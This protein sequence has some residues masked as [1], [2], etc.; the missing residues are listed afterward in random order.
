MLL[1]A[2]RLYIFFPRVK[3]FISFEKKYLFHT[4]FVKQKIILNTNMNT[5]N[6]DFLALIENKIPNFDI[7]SKEIYLDFLPEYLNILLEKE[8]TEFFSD[9]QTEDALIDFELFD[10]ESRL[11]YV[12]WLL[13]HID[14]VYG[15]EKS[16]TIIDEFEPKYIEFSQEV[17]FSKRYYEMYKICL[18]KW[19]LN[20]E[21]EKILKDVI[22]S[23]EVR[24]IHLAEGKQEELKMIGKILAE[25]SRKF[26]EN[27]LLSEWEITFSIEDEDSIEELPNDVKKEA[28]EKAKKQ[29]MR[30][31][32]FWSSP[33]EY[34]SV[35]KY[36]SDKEKRKEI[37]V[38]RSQIASN[39]K[40]DN[41][42]HV[43]DIL[44]LRQ[45]KSEI[46]WF[47]NY[48]DLS[49]YFKMAE[50]ATEVLDLLNSIATR[51]KKKAESEL[52]ML[53]EYFS[54]DTIDSE[55][56]AYYFRK[57]KEL[58]FEID[59]NVIKEYFEY[60][61]VLGW[62]FSIMNKLY[63]VELKQIQEQE[64]N[65]K[66]YE[67][68]KEWKLLSYFLIDPF[69]RP[70]KRSWAWYVGVKEKWH[71]NIPLVVN[72]YNIKKWKNQ[73]LL[74]M[75][76]VETV[77]HE[78]WHAMHNM[79]SMSQY[80][81]LTWTYVEHDFV[82]VPSQF[83]E[84]FCKEKECLELFAKHYKTWKTIP[85]IY[86]KKLEQLEQVGVWNMILWQC[87]YATLDM[88]LHQKR[89]YDSIEDL[90]NYILNL[91]NSISLIPKENSYKMYTSFSHIF[92]GWYASGYY[93][94]LWSEIL[95][96]D[97]WSEFLKAW[98]F[99][100][101]I[102]QKFYNNILS[103]GSKKDAKD[104]FYDFLGREKSVEWFLKAKWI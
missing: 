19:W 46:L 85:E 88:S 52:G 35:M 16:R 42:Q 61:T 70:E 77:F 17:W 33:S 103:Q 81:E 37:F 74:R 21:Q 45:Q 30:G 58:E 92:D 48:S 39:W 62:M 75:S 80:A 68:Y 36:C 49:L 23:Y 7:L 65:V 12:W 89:A 22:K 63:W 95:E 8:K 97:I 53:K 6:K 26:S 14:N 50:N 93:S 25:K 67:V 90:D 94:Y 31:Y 34:I 84:H 9:L 86:I 55:D 38:Q 91:M 44:W 64:N 101:K 60:E 18:A 87:A 13:Q 11:S 66:I 24:G 98:I 32:V 54:L 83:H 3:F 76:E 15:S 99:D 5:I 102:T 72:V 51:A 73:T 100:K 1:K 71:W 47:E 56:T 82:E 40:Y 96:Y 4:L 28:L 79:F 59:E 78:F 27:E 20:W 41:R 69:F 29:W 104:M 2:V 57:Y 10:K 43:L